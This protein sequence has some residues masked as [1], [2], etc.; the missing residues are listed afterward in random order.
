MLLNEF[1][2]NYFSKIM[3]NNSNLIKTKGKVKITL[4]FSYIN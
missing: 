3:F 4:P 1:L 2:P